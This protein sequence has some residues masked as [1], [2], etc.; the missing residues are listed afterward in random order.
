[1]RVEADRYWSNWNDRWVQFVWW[2]DALKA[3]GQGVICQH[4]PESL[5][6]EIN[7]WEIV[8]SVFHRKMTVQIRPKWIGKKWW[9]YHEKGGKVTHITSRF[10]FFSLLDTLLHQP[11][12][13][14]VTKLPL[15]SSQLN[16]LIIVSYH[17]RLPSIKSTTEGFFFPCSIQ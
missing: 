17:Q 6:R 1:M 5:G 12:Y 4:V 3:E 9:G 15:S 13:H 14:P 7:C 16:I 2:I 10:L 8:L 11:V